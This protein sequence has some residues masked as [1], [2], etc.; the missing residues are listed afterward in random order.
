[1]VMP[2]WWHCLSHMRKLSLLTVLNSMVLPSL[3]EMSSSWGPGRRAR[4]GYS[5]PHHLNERL[6][7]LLLIGLMVIRPESNTHL[8]WPSAPQCYCLHSSPRN[9]IKMQ[10]T[11]WLY[12]IHS[13]TH[14]GRLWEGWV[15]VLLRA[16]QVISYHSV[17]STVIRM[18][19]FP[20]IPPGQ[21]LLEMWAINNRNPFSLKSSDFNEDW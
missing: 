18:W 10:S 15:F 2:L 7:F 12:H 5:G 3:A 17:G 1:M 8:G 14:S 11:T 21:N 20:Q 6:P 4:K 16:P 9:A 13:R 19:Y